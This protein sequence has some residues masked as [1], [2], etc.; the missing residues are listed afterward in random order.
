MEQTKKDLV[1]RRK[2][3]D[4]DKVYQQH[5]RGQNLNRFQPH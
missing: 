4:G 2:S 1:D 5:Y 3:G